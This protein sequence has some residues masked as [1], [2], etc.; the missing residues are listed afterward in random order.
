MNFIDF[1]QHYAVQLCPLAAPTPALP[2]GF[3]LEGDANRRKLTL[4]GLAIA[5]PYNPEREA[6]QILEGLFATPPSCLVL[7]GIG[8]G[9]ILE[10]A[11]RFRSD[12]AIFVYEPCPSWI[13]YVHHQ[14]PNLSI[15]QAKSIQWFG[16]GQELT[17]ERAVQ[18]I[19]PAN[20]V[21]Y[22]YN[23]WHHAWP[24]T[25]AIIKATVEA[26][27][28][29][30]QVNVNTLQR[31]GRLWVRNLIN[32]LELFAQEPGIALINQAFTDFPGLLI[33][34]G[35]SLDTVL[36]YLPELR[37]RMVIVAVDTGLRA[38]LHMGIQPDFLCVV[39]PQY[40]NSKHLDHLESPTSIVV[41][42]PSA[43]PR[44]LRHTAK[45]ILF[46]SSIF[47]L[48]AILEQATGRKGSLGAGGSVATSTW[49]FLRQCGVKS[50]WCAGLD[51]SFPGSKTH[52]HGS[53]FE[54]SMHCNS[55]RTKPASDGAF[56]YL[57]DAHAHPCPA[58]DGSM[59]LSDQR[60]DMYAHWFEEQVHSYPNPPTY[61]F[62]ADHRALRGIEAKEINQALQLEVC[63]PAIDQRLTELRSGMEQWRS[64]ALR[65][66]TSRRGQEAFKA[67]DSQIAL[68]VT[69][70]EEAVQ[71][72]QKILAGDENTE[73]LTRLEA[74]DAEVMDSPDK[75]LL[76]FLIEELIQAVQTRPQPK[77]FS[78]AITTSCELYQGLA[79][80]GNFYRKLWERFL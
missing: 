69:K 7:F 46:C 10:H 18:S 75:R 44:S 45:R 41:A 49:D 51:L 54:E 2:T 59:V 27:R 9:L 66:G 58:V 62:V 71:I 48:G 31:F 57:V 78:E 6:R 30:R 38:C 47:P 32:N 11:L 35:P 61:R 4:H 19:H 17:L 72:C 43:T 34:G 36:P 24:E 60:M 56:R 50:I 42:E 3:A 16:P 70:A 67:L 39:D 23:A 25:A 5:S 80:A 76:G 20:L 53:Y 64:E 26:C 21:Y 52:Y 15:W 12:L 22:A 77:A 13:V 37:K 29:R 68:L 74:I 63:R 33:A 28:F 1:L 8:Q 14:N 40:W 73:Y 79:N 55:Y 65:L